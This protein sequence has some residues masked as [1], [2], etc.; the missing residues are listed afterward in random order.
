[1]HSTTHVLHTGCAY[2]CV[3]AH[4]MYRLPLALRI[5]TH[6]HP[7]ATTT[8]GCSGYATWCTTGTQMHTQSACMHTLCVVLCI[9]IVLILALTEDVCIR[10]HG[11]NT[12][13][14]EHQNTATNRVFR[15]STGSRTPRFSHAKREIACFRGVK[16]HDL[17]IVSGESAILAVIWDSDCPTQNTGL[18]PESTIS[19]GRC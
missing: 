3:Y 8:T 18:G 10:V 1:M 7:L 6:N 5:A 19:R 17:A 9:A 11:V 15:V 13:A 14:S 12:C 2:A 4:T 16:W